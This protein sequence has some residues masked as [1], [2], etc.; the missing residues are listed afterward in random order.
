MNLSIQSKLETTYKA[1]WKEDDV[2]IYADNFDCRYAAKG[3]R[4]CAS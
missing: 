3:G 1:A 2:A 4:I